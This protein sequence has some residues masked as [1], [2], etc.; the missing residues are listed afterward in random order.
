MSRRKKDWDK[1]LSYAANIAKDMRNPNKGGNQH[2]SWGIAQKKAWKD[3]RVL[4]RKA[5]YHIKYNHP[6]T[7]ISGNSKN[8]KKPSSG[9][10]KRPRGRP[11]KKPISK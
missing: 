8:N 4:K 9:T 2:L 5:E 6:K 7:K 11:R 3:P 10:K 1:V